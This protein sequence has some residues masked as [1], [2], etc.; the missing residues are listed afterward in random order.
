MCLKRDAIYCTDVDGQAFQL[1]PLIRG[2]DD[3][4]LSQRLDNQI[5]VS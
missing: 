1:A 4:S 2:V 3:F 5:E